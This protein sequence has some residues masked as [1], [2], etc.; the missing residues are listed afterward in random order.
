MA[1]KD[2]VRRSDC[3]I[4]FTLDLI[5][6]RWTLLVIRDLAFLHKRHFREFLASEEKIAS[7]IL[8]SRLKMLEKRGVVVR[9]PDPQSARQAIYELTEKGAGLLPVL[10]ELVRW[11]AKHDVKTAAPRS[12]VRRIERDREGLVRELTALLL[13]KSKR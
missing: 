12:F 6:D 4:A 1:S 3:P 8:A 9:R 7:N 2:R 10:L 13:K 5:G 11:G